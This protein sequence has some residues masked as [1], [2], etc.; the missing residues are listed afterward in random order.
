MY[1]TLQSVSGNNYTY[2]VTLK[3]F[4]DVT[5]GTPLDGTANIAIYDKTNNSLF[6]S[7]AVPLLT[8]SV[9]TLQS[10]GPCVVNPPQVSYNVGLYTFIVTLPSSMMGY[11]I[12]YARCC[13]INGISNLVA[14]SSSYGVTYTAEIPGFE[15]VASAPSNNSAH[16]L[17]IDTVVIC[18][19]YP[20]TYNFAAEDADGDALLYSFCNAYDNTGGTVPNPP[21]PPPYNSLPYEAPF[22][23]L[24]PMGSGVNIDAFSGLIQGTAPTAGIYVVTVCVE[25]WRNGVKIATQR[26]DLQVKVADCDIATVSLEPNGYINCNSTTMTFNNLTPSALITSYFWDFGDL[27]TLGDTSL[28]ASPTYTYP[29]TGV[30]I[31]KV[32]ANRNQACS[33]ST[34]AEVRIY[35]GFTPGFTF[36]GI[37]V[38]SPVQF[39]DVTTA[40][41]G[42]VNFWRYDFGVLSLSN[43]TSRLQNPQYIYTS[44]GTYNIEFMVASDKGCRDTIYQS[45]TI[46]DKPPMSMNFRDTLICSVDTIQ[47]GATGT[48]NFTWTPGYNISNATSANPL[49]WP[50]TDTWYYAEL[51][52]G[53]CKN[54]DSVRV[55]V[56]DFVTLTASNDTTICVNDQVQ[57]FATTNGLQ[58]SWSGA[59]LSNPNILNPVATPVGTTTYQITS[60][61]GGCLAT[62]DVTVNVVPYPVVNA[63]PD[64][65]ICFNTT[66]QLN[67][68]HDGTSFVWTPSASLNNAS[69]L[70][71]IA[72]PTATTQYILT[73]TDNASGC[74]KPA[75]DT[76]IVTVMPE[77]IAFAGRDTMVIAGQPVQLK[78]TGGV[79]YL[80]TPPT[81]LDNPNI[82]GPIALLDGNPDSVYYSVLVMDA[83]GCSDTDTILIRVFKTGP[84]IFVPT[85]F[86]P[87]QDGRNDVF[88]PIYAGMT[89]VDFFRVYN[90]WGQLVFSSTVNGQGWDGTINGIKQNTGTYVWMVQA[91]DFTGKVHFKKGTV[92]LI[93]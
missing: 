63:G 78:A 33:D 57:L 68:S 8:Q 4:R 56:V 87:N 9:I 64:V 89:K 48:G 59:G 88:R 20:F 37:C 40:A 25:E 6:W 53:G 77:V 83:A 2:S 39:N 41:Y 74:P 44:T 36:N 21:A 11:T 27:T 80:W 35:P 5:S 84:D 52:Q 93:R 34:T 50:K 70:N 12:T 16:F 38:N 76:V 62:E 42:T 69:I 67:A 86:T 85:G 3:L 45:I 75:K 71:P 58:Y 60:R 24:S 22:S 26:K 29:D 73:V 28:L 14:P 92:T 10:P 15:P 54:R 1:Y 46:I 61:I 90:R 43:D 66:A 65:S 82:A 19:G 7:S 18:A 55:R 47:L 31:V 81:N 72:S 91:V 23:G 17:G 32:V 51:D 49:V 30:Y 79:S 13:R